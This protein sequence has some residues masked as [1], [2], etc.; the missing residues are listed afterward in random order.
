MDGAAW[1]TD[2][3]LTPGGW[4][5]N[6]EVPADPAPHENLFLVLASH[7]LTRSSPGFSLVCMH[8]REVLSSVTDTFLRTLVLW[9]QPTFPEPV[10]P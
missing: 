6:M 3:F 1:T 7:L 5:F 9:D 10:S 8:V 4:E 2:A